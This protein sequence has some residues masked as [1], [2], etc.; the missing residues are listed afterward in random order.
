[1]STSAWGV[2]HGEVSKGFG[3][4][5]KGLGRKLPGGELRHAKKQVQ[6]QLIKPVTAAPGGSFLDA[7]RPKKTPIGKPIG[8]GNMG[9]TPKVTM[10]KGGTRKRAAEAGWRPSNRRMT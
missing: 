1:M 9:T 6:H 8:L 7:T 10:P 2:E 4:A 5:L 3:G